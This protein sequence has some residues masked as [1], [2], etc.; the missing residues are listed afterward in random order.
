MGRAREVIGFV[1]SSSVESGKG[2]VDIDK[3]LDSEIGNEIKEEVRRAKLA[4][5]RT[6]RLKNELEQRKI[7]RVLEEDGDVEGSVEVSKGSSREKE[8]SGITPLD[9]QA[10]QE[11]DKLSPDERKRVLSLLMLMRSNANGNTSSQA[12]FMLPFM[13][14][15][16]FGNPKSEESKSN[17]SDTLEVVSRILE[18]E[19]RNRLDVKQL[20]DTVGSLLSVTGQVKGGNGDG[21]TSELAKKYIEAVEQPRKSFLEDVMEDPNKQ[22][23][24]ERMFGSKVDKEAIQ[25]QREME[26]DRRKWELALKKFDYETRLNYAKLLGEQRRG[27]MFENGLR[28]VVGAVS[29][30][31]SDEAKREGVTPPVQGYQAPTQSSAS[32]SV[33]VPPLRS[34]TCDKCG[35]PV[36]FVDSVEVQKVRCAVCGTEYARE[37]GVDSSSVSRSVS[38]PVQPVQPVPSVKPSEPPVPPEPVEASVVESPSFGVDDVEHTAEQSEQPE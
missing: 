8:S 12:A 30:A 14:S 31:L 20:V 24:L 29:R 13:L 16:L 25:L 22:A 28:Q 27:D 4:K 21:L 34:F 1:G 37:G 33:P 11:L 9:V 26:N 15:G 3:E 7:A 5:I 36:S 23:L 38:P 32:V 19:G 10:A 35:S 18:F 17:L 6:Y 2:D